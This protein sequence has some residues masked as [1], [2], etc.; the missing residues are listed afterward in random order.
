MAGGG[1]A[2]MGKK[3]KIYVLQ[4]LTKIINRF[5]DLYNKSTLVRAGIAAIAVNFKNAWAIIKAIF[6]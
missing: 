6:R 3:M 5:I 4:N 2:D 1:F